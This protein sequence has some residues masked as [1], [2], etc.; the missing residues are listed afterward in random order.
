MTK[1]LKK[2]FKQKNFRMKKLN[3]FASTAENEKIIIKII[4]KLKEF[5]NWN[6]FLIFEVWDSAGCRVTL[7]KLDMR[8]RC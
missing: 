5:K 4:I 1:K 7:K 2:V 8:Y 3:T 6:V